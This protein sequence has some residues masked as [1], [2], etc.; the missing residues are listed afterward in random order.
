MVS[1]VLNPQAG[2]SE[3]IGYTGAIICN[4]ICI[5]GCLMELAQDRE[6]W[7]TSLRSGF[8]ISDSIKMK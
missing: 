7:H 3:F 6:L 5:I 1:S 2:R 8:Q 4:I